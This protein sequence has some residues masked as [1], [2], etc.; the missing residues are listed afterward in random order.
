MCQSYDIDHH[1]S[2]PL[3]C[4][5]S[6][7]IPN[8]KIFEVVTFGLKLKSMFMQKHC[9]NIYLKKKGFYFSFLFLWSKNISIS[10]TM[11][12]LFGYI[13]CHYIWIPT[14]GLMF[15]KVTEN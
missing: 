11:V 7:Q 2:V 1:L 8:F 12:L 5:I 13:F 4:C 15:V 9:V 3:L 10:W 14:K 6:L